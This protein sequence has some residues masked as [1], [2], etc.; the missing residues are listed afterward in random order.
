MQK[1]AGWVRAQDLKSFKGKRPQ[2]LEGEVEPSDLAQG[3]AGGC[4]LAAALARAKRG[5]A[6]PAP[7]LPV[8][9]S[10]GQSL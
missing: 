1:Q 7:R 6:S 4:W 3:A 2:L 10:H 5:R 9:M 8:E